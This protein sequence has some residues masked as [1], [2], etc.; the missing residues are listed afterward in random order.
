MF[1]GEYRHSIDYKGR[2]S[3][4]KKFRGDLIG[5]VIT[6]GLDGCLF[7]YPKKDWETLSKKIQDL[8]LTKEDARSF[9][10]YIF[11]GAERLD[12]DK[13]GR[14]RIPESLRTYAKLKTEVVLVGVAVRVEVWNKDIWEKYKKRTESEG[15]KTAEKLTGAI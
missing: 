7:L 14:A 5:G 10:R 8:P 11:S 1:L 13:L 9:A 15:E 4:P 6:R 2:L 12:F 3:I